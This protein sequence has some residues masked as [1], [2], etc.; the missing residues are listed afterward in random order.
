MLQFEHEL[1]PGFGLRF[2]GIQSR[3]LNW[4]RYE[5]SL[6]PYESYTIPVTLRD[7]GPDGI[8][9]NGDDPG[10]N[11]TYLEYPGSLQP[12]T[13]QAPWIVND[14]AAN[15]KYTSFEIA[16]SKRLANRWSMQASFS[17]TKIDDTLPNNTAGGTGAF[18]ANTKDPN[19]EIFAADNTKEWQARVSGSYLAAWDLQ[20]SVNYQARSGAYW[21]RLVTYRGGRTIPTLT[22]DTLVELRDTTPDDAPDG[23][24]RRE[25]AAVR[26]RKEPRAAAER[27]QSVQRG[28]DPEHQRAVRAGLQHRHRHYARAAGRVQPV[29]RLLT[30]GFTCTGAIFF[31]ARNS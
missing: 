13:F 24:P 20:L 10:T 8:T 28:H 17:H 7:P 1:M 30:D 16:A 22:P 23:L 15:K 14:D 29:V 19:S 27:L 9:N 5:D 12:A 18:E 31:P 25:A 6:R 26:G 3:A 11:L 2:T 21:G 4:T